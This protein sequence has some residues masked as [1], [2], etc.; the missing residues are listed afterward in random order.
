MLIPPFYLTLCSVH[1]IFVH[2]FKRFYFVTEVKHENNRSMCMYTCRSPPGLE[3]FVSGKD[4]QGFKIKH[5]DKQLKRSFMQ[6]RDK[7][8]S[9]ILII[10]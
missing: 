2:N 1:C 8:E 4:P 10:L 3:A 6:M 5:C 9:S 7:S